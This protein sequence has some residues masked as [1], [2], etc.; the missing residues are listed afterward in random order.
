MDLTYSEWK[1]SNTNKYILCYLYESLGEWCLIYLLKSRLLI[2]KD[3][4]WSDMG[5]REPLDDKN[6]LYLFSMRNNGEGHHHMEKPESCMLNT[7]RWWLCNGLISKRDQGKYG[8]HI[9]YSIF[10]MVNFLLRLKG[11][12]CSQEESFVKVSI[13]T[14]MDA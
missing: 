14:K 3:L 2:T 10:W 9:L 13:K 7:I 8:T 11:E 4:E 5:A 6:I 1:K 12:K